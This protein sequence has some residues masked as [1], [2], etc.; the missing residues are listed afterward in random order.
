[1]KAGHTRVPFSELQAVQRNLRALSDR[2]QKCM[3]ANVDPTSG[4]VQR[5]ID[6]AHS[7]IWRAMRER[8]LDERLDAER[9]ESPAGGNEP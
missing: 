3:R 5:A 6:G 1:M 9:P 8:A 7:L 2:E 4:E